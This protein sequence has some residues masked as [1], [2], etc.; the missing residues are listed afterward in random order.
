VIVAVA[1]VRKPPTDGYDGSLMDA[2]ATQVSGADTVVFPARVSARALD[3]DARFLVQMPDSPTVVI[4]AAPV[5]GGREVPI[6]RVL[7]ARA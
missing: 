4:A 5:I 1:T 2:R 3:G 7:A 6:T